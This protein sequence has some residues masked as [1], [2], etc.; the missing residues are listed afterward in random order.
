MVKWHVLAFAA[1]GTAGAGDSMTWA[2]PFSW[3]RVGA[4]I[5]SALPLLC[6]A[7]LGDLL[8]EG[9]GCL[10]TFWVKL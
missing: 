10:D 2:A 4:R 9:R 7:L 5:V 3:S 6:K 1:E 8:M